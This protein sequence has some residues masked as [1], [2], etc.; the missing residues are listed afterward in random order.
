MRTRRRALT[1]QASW[2]A[3]SAGDD[4]SAEKDIR[5]AGYYAKVFGKVAAAAKAG[6][7]EMAWVKSELKR[8]RMAGVAGEAGVVDVERKANIL[9][10]FVE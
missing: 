4:E 1:S 2:V 9:S 10:S 8:L 5:S 3:S 6:E 7:A